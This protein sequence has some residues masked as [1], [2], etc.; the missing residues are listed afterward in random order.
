M[1]AYRC[2]DCGGV[3]H[4][5]AQLSNPPIHTARCANCGATYRQRKSKPAPLPIDY[6]RVME[7]DA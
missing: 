2:P 7:N 6:E 4:L 3:M 5:T 1:N